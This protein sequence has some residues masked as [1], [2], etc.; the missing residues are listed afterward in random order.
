MPSAADKTSVVLHL[1]AHP[2]AVKRALRAGP[3]PGNVKAV[4]GVLDLHRSNPANEEHGNTTVVLEHSY[5]D[6]EL[7]VFVQR[8]IAKANAE[9]EEMF[10]DSEEDD[11][12]PSSVA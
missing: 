2:K 12:F 10:R 1:E 11:D 5:D 3:E 9:H 6:S 7:R 4:W 8:L